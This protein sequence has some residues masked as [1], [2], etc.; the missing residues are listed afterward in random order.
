M[1]PKPQ[2]PTPLAMRFERL[3]ECLGLD[4]EPDVAATCRWLEQIGCYFCGDYGTD[5]AVSIANEIMAAMEDES[6]Q[7]ELL[8]RRG[9]HWSKLRL[10]ATYQ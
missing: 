3:R 2:A 4:V 9:I 1:T 10:K 5:N 7:K 8:T 6:L